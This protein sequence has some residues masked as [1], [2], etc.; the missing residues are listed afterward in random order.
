VRQLKEELRKETSILTMSEIHL[1]PDKEKP[2]LT[3]NMEGLPLITYLFK[4]VGG[5]DTVLWMYQGKNKSGKRQQF[6]LDTML[7]MPQFDQLILVLIGTVTSLD[8]SEKPYSVAVTITQD[9]KDQRMPID[10]MP[11]TH[12]GRATYDSAVKLHVP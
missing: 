3:I 7:T 4:L 8:E 1:A 5:D 12:N 9:G 6:L 10:N 2:T 11:E